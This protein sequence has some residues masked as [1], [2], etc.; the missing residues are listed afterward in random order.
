MKKFAENVV[1]FLKEEDGPTAVEYAVLLALI[2]VVC[3]GAV[4]TIG[5]NA[6]AKFGEAGAAIAAN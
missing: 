5:S 4:T 2:I 3:I 6:N 1:A